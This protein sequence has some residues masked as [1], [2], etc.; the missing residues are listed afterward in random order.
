MGNHKIILTKQL[1]AIDEIEAASALLYAT[2]IKEYNW[3]FERNNPSL[4]RIETKN[5]RLL[6]VDRFTHAA[7][8]FGAFDGK[9]LIGCVRLT[10]PDENGKFEIQAYPSSH[11]IEKYLCHEN[12]AE[13]SRATVLGSYKGRKIIE[14]LYLEILK[15]A[16]VNNLSI[17]G[18]SNNRFIKTIFKKIGVPLIKENAFKYETNDP[19]P[20]NFYYIDYEQNRFSSIIN[21]LNERII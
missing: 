3:E 11:V 20:V 15:Y 12:T 19:E 5:G 13:V 21:K 8:W 2:Y 18:G 10:F 1:L 14:R 7:I 9:T 17:F 16:S 6:L 4:L